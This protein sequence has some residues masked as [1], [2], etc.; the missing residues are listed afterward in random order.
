MIFIN[1]QEMM[2]YE[3]KPV[4]YAV[5]KMG[6]NTKFLAV[7]Y[8]GKIL[9]KIMYNDTILKDGDVLEVVSFVGGG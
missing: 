3:G 5:E 4:K 7:E 2:Q 1:G 6:Y 9:P 8:N